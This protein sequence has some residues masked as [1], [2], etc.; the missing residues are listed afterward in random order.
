MHRA[1]W[2]VI[3]GV[4]VWSIALVSGPVLRPDLN[5]LTAHPE[6][7]AQGPWAVL[8]QAGYAG[9]AIAG[10]GAAFLARRRPVAA[11]LLALFGIGALALAILPPTGSQANG[12]TFADSLFPYFQLAPLAFFPA[13]AWITWRERGRLLIATAAI[14]WLLFLPLVSGE[15]PSAGLLNR[16]ADLAM[17]AW[18]VAFAAARVSDGRP[19]MRQ[20]LRRDLAFMPTL[21]MRRR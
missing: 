7:Y 10:L 1:E 6:D 13:I 12:G 18:L 4:A 16:G 11:V 19:N 20:D 2:L 15:P 14:A 3:G 17:A 8:M 9:V 5:V 21:R